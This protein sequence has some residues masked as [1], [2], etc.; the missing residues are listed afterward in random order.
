MLRRH[1][2]ASSR[3][4]G[5]RLSRASNCSKATR[6][7]RSH[8]ASRR[9]AAA[10]MAVTRAG[11]SPDRGHERDLTRPPSTP[12]TRR[13]VPSC[14]RW[15]RIPSPRQA[16]RI[17]RR[18]PLESI[19]RIWRGSRRTTRAAA[20]CEQL[21]V[22]ADIAERA[23]VRRRRSTSSTRG[24]ARNSTAIRTALPVGDPGRRR[25]RR[26]AMGPSASCAARLAREPS[27]RSSARAIRAR[28]RRRAEAAQAGIVAAARSPRA[29]CTRRALARVRHPNVV[30]V[31]GADSHDGRV[32]FWMELVEG[33]T[34][35]ERCSQ[36]GRFSAREA[37]L[38]ASICAAR[39]PRCTGADW[40]TA[41]SRRRT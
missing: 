26:R 5:K 4:S 22:V 18:R 13:D 39:S 8:S 30:T 21:R 34:L 14:A 17:R 16:R 9:L 36:T 25:Y 20:S 28:I 11:P 32:G 33:D 27:A 3:P 37:A 6:R 10:R 19:G 35:E 1:W 31:Y 23:P 2:R 40:S 7:S 15:T 41:T 24:P 12:D 29:S 38:S